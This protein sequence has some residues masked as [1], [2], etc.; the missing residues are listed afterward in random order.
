MIKN[1]LATRVLILAACFLLAAG[2]F[3][4][5]AAPGTV[6]PA[7]VPPVAEI[8]ISTDSP[9]V[10]A[11]VEAQP[12]QAL[13]ITQV[14]AQ[15]DVAAQ[16]IG[17]ATVE[18]PA[19]SVVLSGGYATTY[20]MPVFTSMMY[21]NGWDVAAQNTTDEPGTINAYALC[22]QTDSA[23]TSVV[24]Q[25]GMLPANGTGNAQATCPEG[26]IVTG[27]GYS[28]SPMT[29]PFASEP[30]GNGWVI[31][32]TNLY[33]TEAP[34]NVYAVCLSGI[35]GTISVPSSQTA[36]EVNG[37]GIAATGC[38]EG[39]FLVGGGFASGGQSTIFNIS[40]DEGTREWL[41][42]AQDMGAGELIN[43]FAVCLTPQ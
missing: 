43:S 29:I 37:Y 27:G 38:P 9:V 5:C 33:D 31:A 3:S 25:E 15:V 30:E 2:V 23:T 12:P 36:L 19:G 26:T 35:S 13:V 1:H 20:T 16:S 40:M 32:N 11:P 28:S 24:Y 8:G 10:P 39:S 21:G 17:E 42:F 18:C 34:V 7:E 14:L 4:A 22:L 41:V 6:A